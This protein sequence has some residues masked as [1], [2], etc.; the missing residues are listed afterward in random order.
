MEVHGFTSKKRRTFGQQMGL[1]P[2]LEPLVQIFQQK[3]SLFASFLLLLD[4]LHGNRVQIS[5]KHT[6]FRDALYFGDFSS[7]TWIGLIQGMLMCV[8]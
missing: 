7:I 4:S 5:K 2:A 8:H 1:K 6:F 3:K